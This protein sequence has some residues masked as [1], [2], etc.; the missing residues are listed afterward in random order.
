MNLKQL[1]LEIENIIRDYFNQLEHSDKQ[2]ELN[3]EIKS[4]DRDA[5]NYRSWS[6]CWE[7]SG[8]KNYYWE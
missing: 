3:K 4:F 5:Y 7:F 2:W 6:L 8:K 1:P